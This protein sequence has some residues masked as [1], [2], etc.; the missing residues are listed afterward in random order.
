MRWTRRDVLKAGGSIAATRFLWPYGLIGCSSARPLPT[1]LR[2]ETQLPPKYQTELRIPPVLKPTSQTDNIDR[3]ELTAMEATTEIVPGTKTTIW[4]YNG[5]FPGPT[6]EA[7]SGRKTI[8]TLSNQLPVP[9][10]NHLH[11]GRTPS[12]SDGY[13]TDLVLPSQMRFIPG[14]HDPLAKITTAI[15]DYSYPNEQRAA[16]LWYHDHRMDFTGPQMWRGLAGFYILRDEEEDH[17][18][19][20]KGDREIPLMICDRSFGLDGSL[21]Y[22]SLD[23]SLRDTPGVTHGY[24]GGVQGDVILVNGSPWPRLQVAT[25]LYRFRVL[26][27]CNARHLELALDPAPKGGSSFVQIGSDGGLLA[28]PVQYSTL[29]IAPAERFDLVLDFS[30]YPLG[31]KVVLRNR[32]A[33][34]A[35]GE[36]M[37]FDIVRREKSDSTIP[38]RLAQFDRLDRRAAMTTRF[39]DFSYEGMK[40]GWVINGKPF[41]PMRMDAQP[42]LGATEIWRLR[43]DMH[44]PL[45]LHLAHFQ[46]LTHS[47]HPRAYDAG[48]KDTIDMV[49]GETAEILVRFDGYQGRYVF[50]CHNLE[51]EDMAMMGNFEVI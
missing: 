18:P 13:P 31:S 2:S 25:T 23:T 3:Y 46:V 44:H 40:R 20:P 24:M 49:A 15:R 27:A 43:S 26:N 50:H 14:S 22:P 51:H 37:R 34:G 16:T 32:E 4:G 36:I 33:H 30:K 6:I 47:G 39:F 19:L 28:A 17:L 45:H 41:D 12:D 21:L 29:P 35:A 5:H 1:V 42:R 48:W 38:I 9:V 8:V 10:V 7:R 11:G